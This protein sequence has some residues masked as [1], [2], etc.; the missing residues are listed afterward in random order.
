[1]PQ[2]APAFWTPKETAAHLRRAEQTLARWRCEGYGPA[3]IL[4][5][6]RVVYRPEDVD[7]WVAGRR[8]MATAQRPAA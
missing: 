6:R 3:Y 7:A 4:M 2:P 1:M 5:G 8:V